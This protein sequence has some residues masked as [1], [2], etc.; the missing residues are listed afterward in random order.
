MPTKSNGKFAPW[1]E[2]CVSTFW[3][4][5]GV[6]SHMEDETQE[7]IILLCTRIGMI[8]EDASVVAL[9]I[10]SK[11]RGARATTINELNIAAEQID[12]LIKATESLLRHV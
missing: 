11:D 2:S 7:L 3:R 9:T 5:R 12:R 6:V 1:R 8:M 4:G 10:G